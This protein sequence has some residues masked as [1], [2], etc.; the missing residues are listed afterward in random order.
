MHARALLILA[1]CCSQACAVSTFARY[2]A[3][4]SLATYKIDVKAS[5]VVVKGERGKLDSAS[6]AHDE[7]ERIADILN[8]FVHDRSDSARAKPA[9]FLAAVTA[10][11]SSTSI[12]L[13]LEVAGSTIHGSGDAMGSRVVDRDTA[14]YWALKHA[15]ALAVHDA[16]GDTSDIAP[17]FPGRAL[18][19]AGWV[20]TVLSLPVLLPGAIYVRLICGPI[21]GALLIAGLPMLAVGYAKGAAARRSMPP[22]AASAPAFEVRF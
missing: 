13:T 8:D 7:R 6:A 16:T 22:L 15:T 1:A 10:T 21:G 20:L 5:E 19:I 11:D 12:D 18:R 9:R 3:P 14:G 4:E 2:R 17:P